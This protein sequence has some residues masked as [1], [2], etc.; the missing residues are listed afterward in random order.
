MKTTAQYCTIPMEAFVAAAE[1][2]DGMSGAQGP[3]ALALER[4]RLRGHRRV[5]W[6]RHLWEQTAQIPA[7]GL[8]IPHE[9]IDTIC[10]ALN[11]PGEEARFYRL[12]PQGEALSQAIDTLEREW[13][14]SGRGVVGEL[15]ACFA[16]SPSESDF[17][18]L[19]MAPELDPGLRRLYGYLHD[20][21]TLCAPTPWLARVVFGWDLSV[22]L[23][24]ESALVRWL[25]ACPRPGEEHPWSIMARWTVDPRIVNHCC[26]NRDLPPSLQG[27][28]HWIPPADRLSYEPSAVAPLRE[29]IT[30]QDPQRPGRQRYLQ[31]AGTTGVGRKTWTARLCA[32]QGMRVLCLAAPRLLNAETGDTPAVPHVQARERLIAAER[33][34][35]LQGCVLYWAQADRVSRDTWQQAP[36]CAPWQFFGME[37]LGSPL[38][39]ENA[40]DT[41]HFS[42]PLPAQTRAH[43][44]QLLPAH[45]NALDLTALAERFSLTPAE[46]EALAPRAHAGRDALWSAC[47]SLS[48]GRLGSLAALLPCPFNWADIVLP[49]DTIAHL[50]EI[51]A[52]TTHRQ[53][54]YETWGFGRKRPLGRG[55]AALFAGPSGTGKTMAAQ[56]LAAE[57]GVGLFRIDLAGVVSKYIGETEKNLRRIFDEAER[58]NAVL[59]FDEADALFGKRTEVKDAHDRY[60]NIEINYLLQRM[61]AH[62]GLAI[63]A[64]NRKGDIDPAFLRRLRFIIDFPLPGVGE[65]AAIWRLAL[66]EQTPAGETLLEAINWELLAARLEISGAGIK[67]IALAAAFLAC[68]DGRKIGMRHILAASRRELAKQGRLVGGEMWGCPVPHL[69]HTDNAR[70]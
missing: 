29:F 64:T 35:L 31:L 12:H 19:C 8:A 49:V 67:N 69:Q 41:L 10:L 13:V 4:I 53:A 40:V 57:M 1:D 68:G 45:E 56:V 66:P 33:E 38:F 17:L 2:R 32:E 23:T 34:A 48:H 61:E 52:H 51:V 63:L 22:R 62:E 27:A 15:A 7:Q 39:R 30:T 44:A 26:G 18:T 24:P 54:V 50:Q 58:L 20:D 11:T 25:L 59:F 70:Q 5:L 46:I 42:L 3:L 47:R 55:V 21:A 65:R 14:H 6:Q 28:A 9:E 37:H 16:L 36:H 60:A 43:W